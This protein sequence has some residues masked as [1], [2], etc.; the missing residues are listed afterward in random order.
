MH[1][2]V[3]SDELKQLQIY[4]RK[5]WLACGD[6]DDADEENKLEEAFCEAVDK[7]WDLKKIEDDKK[8][9][10]SETQEDL[11]K[12]KEP[13]SQG[14][15]VLQKNH[16]ASEVSTANKNEKAEINGNEAINN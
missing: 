14:A 10:E 11:Q 4:I 2:P 3:T 7:F 5:T 16:D 9:E 6:A 12:A 13:S 1:T 15:E 8:S